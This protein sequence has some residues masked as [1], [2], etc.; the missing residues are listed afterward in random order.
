MTVRSAPADWVGILHLCIRCRLQVL[1]IDIQSADRTVTATSFSAKSVARAQ[2]LRLFRSLAAPARLRS[3]PLPTVAAV[4]FQ[5]SFAVHH[6]SA[7]VPGPEFPAPT[8]AIWVDMAKLVTGGEVSASVTPFCIVAALIGASLSEGALHR[9]RAA[10][11]VQMYALSALVVCSDIG[12]RKVK[13]PRRPHT[14]RTVDHIAHL[15]RWAALGRVR[16]RSS[17]RSTQ[18]GFLHLLPWRWACM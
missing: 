7:S 17:P 14:T 18:S 1:H 12:R 13:N 16:L 5:S 11:S 8:A 15:L 9:P 2:P 4:G 6:C 3:R 10:L